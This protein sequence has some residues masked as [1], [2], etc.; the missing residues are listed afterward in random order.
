MGEHFSALM[1]E[2]GNRTAYGI[3]QEDREK[4]IAQWRIYHMKKEDAEL[5]AKVLNNRALYEAAEEMAD[6]ISD[7]VRLFEFLRKQLPVGESLL[8][9][10][11]RV[12][13]LN[14]LL[15]KVEERDD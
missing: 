14:A 10:D 8:M 13:D 15:A 7:A 9:V 11:R 4:Q 12:N 5:F 2:D 6:E 1:H 3:W